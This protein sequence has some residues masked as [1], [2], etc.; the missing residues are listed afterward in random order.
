MN[1]ALWTIKIEVMFYIAVPMIVWVCRRTN[2]DAVLWALIVLSIIYRLKTAAHE[3]LSV[4]LPG[5]LSF[6]L[7]GTLIYYHLD[8]FKRHGRW[9]MLGSVALFALHTWTGWFALRPLAVGGL[10]LGACLLLPQVKGPTRWGDFSYGTYILHWPI[11]QSMIEA[12][13][14]TV[15]PWRGLAMTVCIVATGAVLSWNFIEKP[16]LAHAKSRKLRQ[17]ALGV[18]ANFPPAVP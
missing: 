7:A 14:F 4:Q 1:G 5:Q 16:C 18:T 13:A 2:R 9:M 6:F 3:T 8:F 10:V 12:G 11:I 17:A 15:H